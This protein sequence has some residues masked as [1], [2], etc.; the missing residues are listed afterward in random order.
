MD[1]IALVFGG[2]ILLVC[3]FALSASR[4]E[5]RGTRRAHAAEGS[6]GGDVTWMSGGSDGGGGSDCGA[7][8]SGAGDGGGCD[9]GGGDGGGGD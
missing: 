3:I 2:A 7:G 1:V 8:D 4:R 6:Y 5:E 9:G